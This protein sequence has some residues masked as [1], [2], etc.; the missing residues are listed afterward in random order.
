[1]DAAERLKRKVA[2][3]ELA[4]IADAGHFAPMGK[5]QECA[6]II[7]DFVHRKFAR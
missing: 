6:R 4:I 5:P 7:A 3:C 2:D 1:M